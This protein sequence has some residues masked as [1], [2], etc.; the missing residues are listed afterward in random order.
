MRLLCL[1][2][3][4]REPRPHGPSVYARGGGHVHRPNEKINLSPWTSSK[5]CLSRMTCESP[6]LK[7]VL[8]YSGSLLMSDLC[9]EPAGLKARRLNIQSAYHRTGL[10]LRRGIVGE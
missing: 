10:A 9:N 7:L 1:G 4:Y 6:R 2:L 8:C 3:S 5:V